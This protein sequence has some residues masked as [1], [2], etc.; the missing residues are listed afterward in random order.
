MQ[1]K[2]V[3]QVLEVGVMIEQGSTVTIND[4]NGKDAVKVVGLD[5]GAV[6]SQERELLAGF[7]GGL[8]YGFKMGHGIA[9]SDE[10]PVR[11][12]GW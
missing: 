11:E 3:Q 7:E 8:S 1:G 4:M 12:Q 2:V 9:P 5:D 10:V 6:A